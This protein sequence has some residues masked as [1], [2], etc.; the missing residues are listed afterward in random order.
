[1]SNE[2]LELGNEWIKDIGEYPPDSP[3]VAQIFSNDSVNG[4][5]VAEGIPHFV[6][7]DITQP[8]SK[9]TPDVKWP[10]PVAL[11]SVRSL[12]FLTNIRASFVS[13]DSYDRLLLDENGVLSERQE[14]VAEYQCQLSEENPCDR[15]TP[16]GL[17]EYHKI[18]P[19]VLQH[20]YIVVYAV[21]DVPPSLKDG[22]LTFPEGALS[23]S[24]KA[25]WMFHL[26]NK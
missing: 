10:E 21:W 4:L 15:L 11:T 6:S 12:R 22:M 18:P 20:P 8:R 2:E 25:H 14:V 7:W 19:E 26:I 5:I 1:M 16:D 24:V 9:A 13:I 17:V 3:P 23:D